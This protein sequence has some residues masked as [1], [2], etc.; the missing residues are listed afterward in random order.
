MKKRV[1]NVKDCKVMSKDEIWNE[2]N[3]RY[4]GG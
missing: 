4:C 1:Y 3:I 2:L